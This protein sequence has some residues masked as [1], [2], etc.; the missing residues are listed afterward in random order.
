[1]GRYDRSVHPSS[2]AQARPSLEKSA[3]RKLAFWGLERKIPFIRHWPVRL[4][5][6][7]EYDTDGRIH[8]DG[9]IVEKR[10]LIAPLLHG[11][12]CR[13]YE[14]GMAGDDL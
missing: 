10:R 8:F 7:Y 3:Y 12:E 9:L 13:L 11:I 2:S 6:Q 4:P 14:Q 5:A 1:V